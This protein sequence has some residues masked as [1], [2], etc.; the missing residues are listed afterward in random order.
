VNAHDA[1]FAMVEV[2]NQR[3]VSYV[4]VGALASMY[5]A[6]SRTT[7]DADF[8]VQLGTIQLSE[9]VRQLGSGF[10]LSHQ[11]E[12]ELFTAGTLFVVTHDKSPVRLDVFLLSSD[13]F[14]QK[15][16]ARRKLVQMLGHE[17][18]IPTPEDIVIQKLRWQRAKDLLDVRDVIAVQEGNL[19]WPYV[20]RWCDAHGTRSALDKVRADVAGL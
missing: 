10:R 8:V 1:A 12:F 5:Y 6:M 17:V 4:L 3:G 2:L 16:F 7:Q 20:E 11:T 19:D 9:I 18:C 13:P 14:A 15:M